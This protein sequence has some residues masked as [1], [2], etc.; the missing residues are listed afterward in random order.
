[1]LSIRKKAPFSKFKPKR[2]IIIVN[3]EGNMLKQKQS[4]CSGIL[5][6]FFLIE[7]EQGHEGT[8][9]K[10]EPDKK[11]QRMP[12]YF[13]WVKSPKRH[14]L[15]PTVLKKLTDDLSEIVSII[16]EKSRRFEEMPND[17]RKPTL[18]SCY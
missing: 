18:V 16:S 12:V 13:E 8:E 17:Q 15:Y 2:K 14:Q 1:M 5:I 9:L 7:K 10:P 3:E 6:H 11:Y 4:Y